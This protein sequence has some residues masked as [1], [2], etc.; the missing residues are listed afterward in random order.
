MKVILKKYL[1][2][3]ILINVFFS[4]C[5]NQTTTEDNEK[6]HPEKDNSKVALTTE[7]Y[8]VADIQLGKIEKKNLIIM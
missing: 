4:G 3:L 2:L 6:E 1:L 5:N 7:Q 8:K